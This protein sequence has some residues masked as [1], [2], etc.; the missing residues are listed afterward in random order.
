MT[1]KRILKDS[2]V[3]VTGATDMDVEWV[4]GESITF[5]PRYIFTGLGLLPVP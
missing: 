3:L 1:D 4:R 5:M 2:R